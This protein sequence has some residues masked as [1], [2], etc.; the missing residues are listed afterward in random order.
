MKTRV[1]QVQFHLDEDQLAAVLANYI[2]GYGTDYDEPVDKVPSMWVRECVR[3]YLRWYGDSALYPE[4]DVDVTE[5]HR[6]AVR[7]AYAL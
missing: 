2:A 1:V 4:E 6:V 5:H 7:K 3:K